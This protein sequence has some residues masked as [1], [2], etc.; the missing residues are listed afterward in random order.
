M[1]ILMLLGKDGKEHL[2]WSGDIMPSPRP[3]RAL[4]DWLDVWARVERERAPQ[5]WSKSGPNP[6][7]SPLID[8]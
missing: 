1:A 6:R 4:G 8:G 2:V 3:A 7:I 5:D